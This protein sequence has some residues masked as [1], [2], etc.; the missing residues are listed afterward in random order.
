MMIEDTLREEEELE[1][2]IERHDSAETTIMVVVSISP[3]DVIMH[4]KNVTDGVRT[5]TNQD[6][7]VKTAQTPSVST[8]DI[9]NP[10]N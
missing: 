9:P 2:L 5:A 1:T 10:V 8:L 4:M 7:S 6:I 3:S